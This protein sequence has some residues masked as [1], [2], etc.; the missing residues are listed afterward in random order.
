MIV[1][2]GGR[3]ERLEQGRADEPRHMRRADDDIVAGQATHG[4]GGED[5]PEPT[6][7][8]GIVGDDA[9]EASVVPRHEVHLVDRDD[10]LADAEQVDE[11]AVPPRL[12]EDAGARVD[13][14]DREVGGRGAGHHVAGV[15]D[16][17]RRVGDD[18]LARRRGE[19]AVGDID[20]DALLAL[21]GE[22]VDEE[23]VVEV[24]PL[25]A[26]PCAVVGEHRELVG[27]DRAGVGEQAAN[28]RRLAVVDRPAGDETEEG[29]HGVMVASG[30]I[31]HH[32]SSSRRK[33]EPKV[34]AH[35]CNS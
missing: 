28:Q 23:G 16:V 13:Q 31:A 8:G 10:D 1:G 3:I 4:H 15:L 18:E 2:P 27:G 32:G 26:R 20:R 29:G 21:G 7:E 19:E 5:Q 6:G 14:D 25:C 9:V 11:E 17:A 12:L 34:V 22:P 35:L 24:G 33:P 30:L